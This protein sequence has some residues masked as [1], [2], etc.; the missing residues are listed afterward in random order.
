MPQPNMTKIE[1]CNALGKTLSDGVKECK[2]KTGSEACSCWAN[3]TLK[4]T[5]DDLKKCDYK[6]TISSFE[7]K[8]FKTYEYFYL[9]YV[10]ITI[11]FRT[12]PMP[13]KPLSRVASLPLALV[14]NM[15]MMFSPLL[16]H[17]AR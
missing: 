10:F 5:F 9:I 6:V 7:P 4:T 17:A 11:Y 15:R 16:S 13:S 1:A 12:N 2:G 8:T 14:E 3:E